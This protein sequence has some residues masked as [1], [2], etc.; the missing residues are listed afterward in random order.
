M[1]RFRTLYSRSLQVVALVGVFIFFE[2]TLAGAATLYVN[3]DA[4]GANDGSS[5]TD[6]YNDLQ[7]ALAAAGAGDAIWVAA[8][9]YLPGT[10]ETDSFRLKN[11]VE[12]YGGFQGVPGSED[13][14]DA[15]D[16]DTF[17]SILS[18]GPGW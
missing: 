5:W 17:L 11:G 3:D 15:R 1:N 16:V 7:D 14:F 4:G 13:D 9:L 10:L 6:A 8:G 12:I 2:A 18:G